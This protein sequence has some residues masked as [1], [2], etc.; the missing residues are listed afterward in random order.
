M[1]LIAVLVLITVFF[2]LVQ[3]IRS[4]KKVT[5][6]D[7]YFLADKKLG[8]NDFI[9]SSVAYGYQIAALVLFATWGYLYGFWT[10]WV[11]I[12]WGLGFQILK[13][14]NDKG[15]L[16][17][18]YTKVN[19]GTIHSFLAKTHNSRIISKIAGIVTLIGLSGTAFFEAEFASDA[20][21]E[22]LPV[23]KLAGNI[24][25]LHI[26]GFYII[27]ILFTL[28]YVSYGGFKAVTTTD[29]LQLK[30]GYVFFNLFVLYTYIKVIDQG[31]FWTGI[32]LM[33]LSFIASIFL[34]YHFKKMYSTN[35]NVIKEKYPSTLVISFFSYIIAF[36]YLLFNLTQ[37]NFEYKDS[38][39]F[40]FVSQ[41]FD[42]PFSLGYLSIIG[43]LIA[44]GLWQIVDVSNWQRLS[45][46]NN[47]SSVKKE[48]SQALHFTSYYSPVTWLLAIFFGMGI[49]YTGV[50]I[51]DAWSAL[52]DFI[53]VSVSEGGIIDSF[54]VYILLISIIF[55]MFST[56][57]SL[58]SSISFTTHY[59]ILSKSNKSLSN[60]ILYTVLY[61]VIFMIIYLFVRQKINQVD[62][63]LY[64]FYSF[65][66][67]L[68]PSIISVLL[69]RKANYR[70]S[71]YSILGG[72]ALTLI[73]FFINNEIINPYSSSSIFSVV[74]SCLIYYLITIFYKR[75][76]I[77][78]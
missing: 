12:F 15:K 53:K 1:N 30:V 75:D 60:A 59:D 47:L 35:F 9:N 69:F 2:L 10:I 65:Q 67:S 27:F 70:S 62:S 25:N 3:K 40:F 58:I 5:T 48:I 28:F 43:L 45:S 38:I 22:I 49:K 33:L 6:I 55:I 11:P 21:I 46:I 13:T 16:D 72:S 74:G 76:T 31:Y 44:N 71:I 17:I 7:E 57:D 23:K 26:N 14:F 34:L 64:T 19:N 63:I 24:G 73:P 61:T 78:M 20:I 8:S 68:F 56:L 42:E 50:E 4:I 37:S 32:S 51:T 77:N 66:L 18:F 29:K 52:K 39:S 41:K 36:I 54:F